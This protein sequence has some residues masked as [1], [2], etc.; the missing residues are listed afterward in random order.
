MLATAA[1][2]ELLG[3]LAV[4]DYIDVVMVAPIVTAG[5]RRPP[6]QRLHLKPARST[7]FPTPYDGQR[8]ASG[9]WA[10]GHAWR[11]R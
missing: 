10:S 6:L 1:T 11:A 2:F 5:L 3:R 9:L 7:C 8:H 4:P